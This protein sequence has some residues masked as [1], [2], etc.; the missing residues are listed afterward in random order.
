MSGLF[1]LQTLRQESNENFIGFDEDTITMRLE[2]AFDKMEAVADIIDK[3]SGFSL[4]PMEANFLQARLD[5][6]TGGVYSTT[7]RM[8][9]NKTVQE[10]LILRCEGFFSDIWKSIKEFFTWLGGRISAIFS[11]DDEVSDSTASAN[12]ATAA[13]ELAGLPMKELTT[14]G[15]L[16]KIFNFSSVAEVQ[17]DVDLFNNSVTAVIALTKEILDYVEEVIKKDDKKK[18]KAAIGDLIKKVQAKSP[19]SLKAKHKG[20]AFFVRSNLVYV[21]SVEDSAFKLNK[22]E[23]ELKKEAIALDGNSMIKVLEAVKTSIKPCE[24]LRDVFKAV[25][26]PKSNEISKSFEAL[27]KTED[28]KNKE[29]IG[30]VREAVSLMRGYT[31]LCLKLNNNGKTIRKVMGEPLAAVKQ[32]R[33][34]AE[35]EKADKKAASQAAKEQK[36]KEAKEKASKILNSN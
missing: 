11:G 35:K 25:I 18:T 26:G 12:V 21:F 29:R 2:A 17:K 15:G 9:A 16:E 13:K 31:D 10:V 6:I 34:K 7:V 1:S 23:I 19:A 5:S 3:A 8:E 30:H 20:A 27:A 36:D 32:M 22:K 24:D 14:V 33:E 28:D 4:R